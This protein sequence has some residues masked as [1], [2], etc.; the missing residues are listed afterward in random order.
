MW[1]HF[2]TSRPNSLARHDNFGL[3]TCL[4]TQIRWASQAAAVKETEA[5]GSKI[6]IGPKPKQIKEDDEDANL[7]YQGP[8]SSTIKKV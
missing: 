4:H 8:I 6:S 3:V 2:S 1:R 7:V 5:S